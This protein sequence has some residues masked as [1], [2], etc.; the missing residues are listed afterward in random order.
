M[1]DDRARL[2]GQYEYDEYVDR[3]RF[4]PGGS[5]G[6][7]RVGGRSSTLTAACS[8]LSLASCGCALWRALCV[9]TPSSPDV[10][11][12]QFGPLKVAAAAFDAETPAE[13]SALL[14]FGTLS[15]SV[16]EN[17][18]EFLGIP[19][20]SPFKRLEPPQPWSASFDSGHRW[21]GAFGPACRQLSSRTQ[22]AFKLMSEDC[23]TLN[24]YTPRRE[25]LATSAERLPVLVYV[26]GGS[27][28]Y[29]GSSDPRYN[30]S[31][32]AARH[33]VLVVTINYRLGPYG[34]LALRDSPMNSGG[35]INSG[36]LQS[37]G[38]LD[39]QMALRWVRDHIGA[40]GGDASRV[41]LFGQSAGA[42]SVCTHL[43]VPS[44][45]GLFAGALLESGHCDARPLRSA[46]ALSRSFCAKAGCASTADASCDARCLRAAPLASWTGAWALMP[47]GFAGAWQPVVDGELLAD[48]PLRLLQAGKFHRVP[49]VMGTNSNEGTSFAYLEYFDRMLSTDL[50]REIKSYLSG[51]AETYP[52]FGA[53]EA[54]AHV[55]SLYPPP[56][57][58]TSDCRPHWAAALGDG[59]FTCVTMAAARAAAQYTY[60]YHYRFDE[61]CSPGR[62]PESWGVFHEAEIPYVWGRDDSNCLSTDADHSLSRAV[63][64][65]WTAFARSGVPSLGNLGTDER[66]V[67]WPRVNA[68]EKATLYSLRLR[69]PL[70]FQ[71]ES[72]WRQQE[73]AVWAPLYEE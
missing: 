37:L 39:Q 34:F 72:G 14:P 67:E 16:L 55:T 27:F 4:Q 63:G 1:R 56:D 25:S 73:C 33:K 36:G 5:A 42:V 50:P 49:I 41:L 29:G 38:I 35:L 17:H 13:G 48:Q 31:F 23:G 20:A 19:Y 26:H 53:V 44:S 6:R 18:V 64:K 66:H 43:V 62:V 54:A 47:A 70:P 58:A 8:L 2:G 10:P 46:L 28:V 45:R 57:D 30:G 40:F 32:L 69:A 15:G 11:A 71:V 3:P 22:P 52:A 61:R 9:T 12:S 21:A 51:M 65:L 59:R 60:V 7:W 68:S 24:I